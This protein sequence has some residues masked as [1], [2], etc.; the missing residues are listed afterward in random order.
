MMLGGVDPYAMG[1]MNPY[2]SVPMYSPY[3]APMDP[4]SMGM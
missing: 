3:M 1:M 4:N 2:G